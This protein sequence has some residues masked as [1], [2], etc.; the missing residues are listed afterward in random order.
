MLRVLLCT[1]CLLV[2]AAHAAEPSLEPKLVVLVPQAVREPKVAPAPE[3]AAASDGLAT[4]WWL[5]AAA[6]VVATG[7]LAGAA[8]AMGAPQPRNTTLADGDFRKGN[9]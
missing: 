5:W 7:L 3:T 4:K 8:L 2:S 9:P 1:G 6:G